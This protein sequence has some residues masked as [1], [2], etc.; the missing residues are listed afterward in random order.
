MAKLQILMLCV[1]TLPETIAEIMQCYR[2]LKAM[3]LNLDA[4]GFTAPSYFE[5]S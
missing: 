5:N 3:F 4:D 2:L 1:D